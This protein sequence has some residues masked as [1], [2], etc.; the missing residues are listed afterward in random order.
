MSKKEDYYVE[1]IRLRNKYLKSKNKDHKEPSNL[2]L[3]EYKLAPWSDEFYGFPFQ[4]ILDEN[5]EDVKVC[6]ISAPLYE[7]DRVKFK[8]IIAKGYLYIGISSYGFYPLYNEDDAKNDNRAE[9]LLNKEM[10]DIINGASGW[11]YC[12]TNYDFLPNIPKLLFSE[13]DIP[14]MNYIK[15]KNLPKEYDVI[16]NSG[17]NALFHRY[18]KNWDLAKKCI[19]LML[20][21]GLK[22]LII[23]REEMDDPSENHSNLILKKFLPYYEFLDEIEKSKVLFVPNISDASPRIITE[24]LIK[25][26]PILVNKKIF[27]GW[28]YVNEYTGSYFKNES[29][30]MKKLK[31]I[32][33]KIDNKEYSTRKWFE[34]NYFSDGKSRS[35]GKLKEFIEKIKKNK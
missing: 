27:G 30:I 26:V 34:R 18:H 15:V 35:N 4:R 29:D 16:Y 5:N 2:V 28:K 1:Y 19:K 20:D 7:G 31:I 14:Y 24:S 25:D 10:K 32:I 23:G 22:V 17:S 33:N 8:E 21:S 3:G 9:E 11:L 6:V 13:S 12:T